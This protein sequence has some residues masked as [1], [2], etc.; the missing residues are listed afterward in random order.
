MAE[1]QVPLD[2]N[3]T[4][5]DAS[6]MGMDSVMSAIVS[7]E[8]VYPISIRDGRST[9]IVQDKNSAYVFINGIVFALGQMEE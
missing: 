4:I 8:A 2:K 5:L 7:D 6:E 3:Q 1:T 9:Y